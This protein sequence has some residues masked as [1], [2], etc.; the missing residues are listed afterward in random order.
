MCICWQYKHCLL[1]P[2]QVLITVD[3]VTELRQA[4]Q[5]TSLSDYQKL[6][7]QLTEF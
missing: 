1:S 5:H 3:A 2:L 4:S 6:I 7:A